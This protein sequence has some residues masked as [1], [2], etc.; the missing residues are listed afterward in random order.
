M[1]M[2]NDDDEVEGSFNAFKGDLNR[3]I[4]Q[5]TRNFYFIGFF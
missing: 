5:F 2:N 3:Q 1:V 4:K